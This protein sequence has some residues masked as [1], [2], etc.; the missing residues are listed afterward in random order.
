MEVEPTGQRG[1]NGN[2]AVAGAA[3]EAFAGWLQPVTHSASRDTRQVLCELWTLIAA[4]SPFVRFLV[5]LLYNLFYDKSTTNRTSGVWAHMPPPAST[6]EGQGRNIVSRSYTLWFTGYVTVSVGTRA[7]C[8]P[9]EAPNGGTT[10]ATPCVNRSARSTDDSHG[11]Q[12]IHQHA[13]C[14]QTRSTDRVNQTTDR[15]SVALKILRRSMKKVSS[16]D[17]TSIEVW[18]DLCTTLYAS[19]V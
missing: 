4:Q 9:F 10:L 18:A 14:P 8:R 5:D 16:L 12:P 11:P 1:R 7:L 13:W 3:S 17:L 15:C 19:C 6:G 2:E